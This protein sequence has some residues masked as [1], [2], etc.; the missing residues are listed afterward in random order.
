MAWR[1]SGGCRPGI[2]ALLNLVLVLQLCFLVCIM[3]NRCSGR[4]SSFRFSSDGLGFSVNVGRGLQCSVPTS[5]SMT[6]YRSWP[7]GTSSIGTEAFGGG[8]FDGSSIWLVPSGSN[9]VIRLNLSSGSMTAFGNWPPGTSSIGT[10]AFFG[11][12]F[13]GS[14]IWLA[15]YNSDRLVRVDPLS[16]NMTGFRNWPNGTSNMGKLAFVGAVFDGLSIWLVPSHADR[17]IRVDPSSGNMTGYRA[18]P[19]GTSSIGNYA[20]HG[21]IFNGSSIWLLPHNSD[22]VVRIDRMSGNMT[23]YRNWPNG[24]TNVGNAAFAG[25]VFDGSHI[26]LVPCRS[27]RVVRLDT[28]TGN[29]TGYGNWPPGTSSIGNYAFYGGIFDGSYIWLVPYNSDRLI[30]IDPSSGNMTGYRNWPTGTTGI[31]SSAFVGGAFYNSSIWLVPYGADRAV[32]VELNCTTNYT[33]TATRG[34]PS[35]SVSA[36]E[37]LS[38]TASTTAT[39]SLSLPCLAS[40]RCSGN[41]TVVGDTTTTTGCGCRCVNG[42]NASTNCSTPL[43]CPSSMCNGMGNITGDLV[44]GCLCECLPGY[45]PATNC[46][47]ASAVPTGTSAAPSVINYTASP[48]QNPSCPFD[49]VGNSTLL[50]PYESMVLSNESGISTTSVCDSEQSCVVSMRAC[51]ATSDSGPTPISCDDA[52]YCTRVFMECLFL[53]A[54]NSTQ[55][56]PRLA[57]LNASLR[58]VQ[59]KSTLYSGSA[60]YFSCAASSCRIL[61]WL[62]PGPTDLRSTTPAVATCPSPRFIINSPQRPSRLYGSPTITVVSVA[63]RSNTAAL[64]VVATGTAALGFGAAAGVSSLPALTKGPVLEALTGVV[65]CAF[66][67]EDTEPSQFDFPVRASIGTSEFASFVGSGFATLMVLVVLPMLIAFVFKWVGWRWRHGPV[68]Q[69]KV[70]ANG[71]Q[72]AFSYFGPLMFR[73][74]ILII[75]HSRPA[76]DIAI[77][78][79]CPVVV[80]GLAL[81]LLYVVARELESAVT[82]SQ[83]EEGSTE[84]EYE[85]KDPKSLF[86]ETFGLLFDM[87]RSLRLRHRLLYFEDLLVAS[88]LQLLAG[89]RPERA[90]S[91][92][93]VASLMS[94][95][96]WLHSLYLLINRPFNE[97]LELWLVVGGSLILS[98]LATLGTVITF[99]VSPDDVEQSPLYEAFSYLGL[100]AMLYF[101]IQTGA[102]AFAEIAEAQKERL[103]NLWDKQGDP[104]G[105]ADQESQPHGGESTDR[106]SPVGHRFESGSPA[107]VPGMPLLAQPLLLHGGNQDSPFLGLEQSSRSPQTSSLLLNPLGTSRCPQ[108]DDG[109]PLVY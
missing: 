76:G 6:G 37:T 21:G 28:S 40:H 54:M 39:W 75:W 2:L 96:C 65:Q 34:S 102:L 44:V 107:L 89:V 9:R 25:G 20:F 61:Q 71:A 101:F 57:P 5:V 13:D 79:L 4:S 8:V 103:E 70:I 23:G 62:R 84:L 85:N 63:V 38:S 69:Q 50:I 10:Y 32:S 87:A 53:M 26:W 52:V 108:L 43:L 42:Y 12:T 67:D 47:A 35:K 1:C 82:V 77:A 68:V 27:N 80:L 98:V 46:S 29:M 49:S 91:C 88:I 3:P 31:G 24:T 60:A 45:D 93:A 81:Y 73:L 74:P 22:R 99:T 83:P 56:C 18:W 59:L 90:N 66:T 86:F 17:V 78:V 105:L 100:C 48:L 94:I 41:A 30:R 55:R 19:N 15:P 33:A 7:T 104:S 14:S 92:G 16:G 106:S 72:V 51:T 36:S 109:R 11:G 64:V 97:K 58:S 95:V